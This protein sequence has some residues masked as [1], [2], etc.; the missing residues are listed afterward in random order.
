MSNKNNPIIF[1]VK[2]E[3]L[4]T[5]KSFL[6]FCNYDYHQTCKLDI[7]ADFLRAAEKDNFIHPLL[8][9]KENIRQEDATEKEVVVNY[10]S[11]HQIYI[12]AALSKNQVHEGLLWEKSDLEFYKQ[13]GFRMVNWGW[14]G[15]A[16]NITLEQKNKVFRIVNQQRLGK[17]N[18]IAIEEGKSSRDPNFD[19]L[20][21]C[22]DFQNFLILLHSLKQLQYSPT[23]DRT[24]DRYFAE[25]PSLYFD[26]SSLKTEGDKMLNKYRLN[27]GKLII[28]AQNVARLASDID[29]MKY[30]Y[31]Y[32]NRHPQRRKDLFKGEALLAQ[33][34]YAIY[35]LIVNVAE[36]LSGEKSPPMFEFLY[37][38]QNINPYLIP[39]AEYVHGTD[40]KS[41]WEAIKKFK[42]WMKLENNKVFVEEA[43]LR[44]L[45]NFEKELQEYEEKYE[46]RNFISNGIR[47]VESEELLKLEDLDPKTKQY[48]NQ[49]IS[50]A[51]TELSQSKRQFLSFLDD[52]LEESVKK[53]ELTLNEAKKE[54]YAL[55]VKREIFDAIEQRLSSLK[56]ELWAILETVHE[57]IS[58]NVDEAWGIEHNFG[59]HFWFKRKNELEKLSQEERHKLY[60]SEYRKAYENAKQWSKKR[61]EFGNIQFTMDLLFCKVCREN[62]VMIHQDHN[63]DKISN[64]V[65]CDDCIKNA[66]DPKTIKPAEL[67]CDYCGSLLYKYAYLNR[68]NDKLFNAAPADIDVELEYGRLNVKIKC[69]K[70]GQ[71]NLRRIDWGWVA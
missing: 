13:Q 68:L 11:P 47:E 7:N 52:E 59:N 14:S 25:A 15:Y 28:L 16:F 57:K 56:R 10:Y 37:G 45:E 61:D 46:A 2:K 63:D 40:V 39:R 51:T 33:E 50:Q 48:A 66:E 64:E 49:I 65:I 69:K 30:W 41:M 24:K 20:K 6:R 38:E 29:P 44:R 19:Y 1:D 23:N 22:S 18:I 71:T 42:V 55:F 70:C 54:D 27:L 67:N 32:I 5:E 53:G 4:F 9:I 21:V 3:Q 35:D 58:K 62:P 34:L 26:L 43:T 31:Y 12:V 17:A 8:Q 36:V 60:E